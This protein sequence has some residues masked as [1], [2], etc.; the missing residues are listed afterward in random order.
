MSLAAAVKQLPGWWYVLDLL[1]PVMAG[2]VPQY[3][4][5][6]LTGKNG[7]V[8]NKFLLARNVGVVG[9]KKLAATVRGFRIF[10]RRRARQSVARIGCC[11]KHAVE[12]VWAFIRVHLGIGIRIAWTGCTYFLCEVR[13]E[14][15]YCLFD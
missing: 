5:S 2:A 3:V 13:C 12:P 9:I 8:P 1:S 15:E 10:R 6:L 7:F 14:E 11:A 4:L